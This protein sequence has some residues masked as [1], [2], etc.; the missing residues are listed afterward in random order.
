MT[1]DD[2]DAPAQPTVDVPLLDSAS[3]PPLIEIITS[4]LE[5]GPRAYKMLGVDRGSTPQAVLKT[6]VADCSAVAK[7]NVLTALEQVISSLADGSDANDT[8]SN[9]LLVRALNLL[10]MVLLE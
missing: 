8:Q 2:A 6:L 5:G 7:R 9:Q 4:A 1:N 3:V 10:E